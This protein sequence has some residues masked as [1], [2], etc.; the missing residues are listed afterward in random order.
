MLPARPRRCAPMTGAG[1]RN[2]GSPARRSGAP[3][4]SDAAGRRSAAGNAA[5]SVSSTAARPLRGPCW[6]STG[7]RPPTYRRLSPPPAD[8][9]V[10]RS[11]MRGDLVAQQALGSRAQDAHLLLQEHVARH[12]QPHER[13]APRVRGQLLPR[14]PIDHPDE[15]HLVTVRFEQRRHSPGDISAQRESQQAD[16]ARGAHHESPSRM[17]RPSRRAC[18]LRKIALYQ[19]RLD[20]QQRKFGRQVSG[21]CRCRCRRRRRQ[22][23][24]RTPGCRYRP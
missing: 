2:R 24:S 23:G 13:L 5:R 15:L 12:R 11:T 18:V 10:T 8:S 16:T 3:E 1:C 19:P 4:N 20:A 6:W 9:P 17:R 21:K 22:D 14:I 7:S